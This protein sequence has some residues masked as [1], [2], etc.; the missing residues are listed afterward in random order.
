MNNRFDENGHNWPIMANYER[1]VG[2]IDSKQ[3]FLNS[4]DQ[5]AS[6]STPQG[7]ARPWGGKFDFLA[8]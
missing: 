8:N 5:Y 3:I 1:T 2:L 4:G 7:Y 6:F